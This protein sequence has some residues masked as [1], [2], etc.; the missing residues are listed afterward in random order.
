MNSSDIYLKITKNILESINSFEKQEFD[1]SEFNNNLLL[2]LS[3]LTKFVAGKNVQE[4]PNFN[5]FISRKNSFLNNQVNQNIMKEN[6]NEE[7]FKNNI[8]DTLNLNPN[9]DKC[10]ER[11]QDLDTTNVDNIT[12]NIEDNFKMDSR[13]SISIFNENLDETYNKTMINTNKNNFL[14]LEKKEF[15]HIDRNLS[16]FDMEQSVCN[17]MSTILGNNDNFN[18]SIFEQDLSII[19]KKDYI[20]KEKNLNLLSTTA[21]KTPFIDE[22]N[23][24]NR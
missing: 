3:F 17:D 4:N 19:F 13:H 18:Q 5:L 10:K 14:D 24:I 1:K 21:N 22:G 11:E 15:M 16:I 6:Y 8:N 2:N 12:E 7:K 20:E 23:K 9:N